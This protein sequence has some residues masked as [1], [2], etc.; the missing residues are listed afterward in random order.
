MTHVFPFDQ[1]QH[2]QPQIMTAVN[3]DHQPQIMGTAK[4]DQPQ[5]I[6]T[7]NEDHQPQYVDK[8]EK[9][10]LW[11]CTGQRV[12]RQKAEAKALAL[13]A[14]PAKAKAEAALRDQ[15]KDADTSNAVS[16]LSRE[17]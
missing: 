5:I 2:H 7:A 3:E 6:G 11:Y 14:D 12:K 9:F 13:L 17:E 1:Q 15:F 16:S 8:G 4:E 10:R